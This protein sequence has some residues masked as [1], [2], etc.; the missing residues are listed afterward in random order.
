MLTESST[1]ELEIE[2]A[3][4]Q[5]VKPIVRNL[6]FVLKCLLCLHF[7]WEVNWWDFGF[8]SFLSV[9]PTSVEVGDKRLNVQNQGRCAG[10]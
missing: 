9:H 6:C 10:G 2:Q 8:P 1:R 7:A 5:E 4:F 3:E